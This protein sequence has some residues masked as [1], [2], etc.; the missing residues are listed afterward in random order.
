[1]QS[2]KVDSEIYES[3]QRCGTGIVECQLVQVREEKSDNSKK[4]SFCDHDSVVIMDESLDGQGEPSYRKTKSPSKAKL[5]EEKEG[6]KPIVKEFDAG[7]PSKLI[8]TKLGAPP[9]AVK[10]LDLKL[11]KDYIFGVS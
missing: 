7:P 5:F 11:I 8:S 4:V 6:R 1:M 2:V 9:P 10:K 3:A